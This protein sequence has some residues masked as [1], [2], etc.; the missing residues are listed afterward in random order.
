MISWCR[1][2]CKEA[3]RLAAP[4]ALVTVDFAE[5]FPQA[6]SGDPLEA[7]VVTS[8]TDAVQS[9]VVSAKRNS[10]NDL[11][12]LSLQN[13]GKLG[14]IFGTNFRTAEQSIVGHA[15]GAKAIGVAGVDAANFGLQTIA[16]FSA[17]GPVIT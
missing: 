17:R 10:G 16:S 2:Y 3:R 8:K 7:L 1:A 4:I 11:V 5:D 13:N 15:G 9:F 14:S 6:G 12:G